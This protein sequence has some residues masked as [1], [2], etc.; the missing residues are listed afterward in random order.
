MRRVA[1]LADGWLASAYNLTPARVVDA[2][3]V[4]AQALATQG[5]Q[6]DD[7]PCALVTMWT[8]VTDDR[9]ERDRRLA[10][11]AEVVNRPPD[12]LLGQVLIGP[13][14]ECAAVLRAFAAAGIEQVFVWPLADAEH[15]LERVMRDV[16]PLLGP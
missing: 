3:A 16:V 13:P 8:Y 2:R 1:R 10:A 9:G 15:Q 11:L 7:F 14:D 12:S 5:R 6:I 4:L